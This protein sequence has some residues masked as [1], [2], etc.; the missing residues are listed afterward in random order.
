MGSVNPTQIQRREERERLARAKSIHAYTQSVNNPIHDKQ[1][2]FLQFFS[3]IKRKK[4]KPK[5]KIK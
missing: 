1:K 3:E 5:Y 2:I 4:E